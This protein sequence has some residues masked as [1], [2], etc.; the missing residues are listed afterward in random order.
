[1]RNIVI[2]PERVGDYIS[3][4]ISLKKPSTKSTLQSTI[5]LWSLFLGAPPDTPESFKLIQQA[6]QIEAVSFL[7]Y[8]KTR[9]GRPPRRKLTKTDGILLQDALIPEGKQIVGLA[10]SSIDVKARMLR[11]LYEYLRD[12][13]IIAENPFKK[14]GKRRTGVES[15]RRPTEVVPYDKVPEMIRYTKTNPLVAGRDYAILSILFGGGLRCSEVLNLN[16]DDIRETRGG[17]VYLTLR[18]TKSGLDQRQA[19]PPWAASAVAAYRD[20]RIREGAGA[21]APVFPNNRTKERLT[22]KG[23]RYIFN[24]YAKLV[25]LDGIISTHSARATFITKLLDQGIDL[26]EVQKASRHSS[27]DMVAIYD[28]RYRGLDDAVSTQVS[29]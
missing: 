2:P 8:L 26:L 9:P 27:L 20:T 18:D 21:L 25:G 16:I 7:E 24:H 15:G 14:L 13:E 17:T 1:M 29:F 6:T 5:K 22:P 19:L 4:Y 28:K 3:S 23:V 11:S 12:H 10:S